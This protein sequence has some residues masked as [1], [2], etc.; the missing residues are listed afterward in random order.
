MKRGRIL[1]RTEK[2]PRE[3]TE[4]RVGKIAYDISRRFHRLGDENLAKHGVTLAQL[5]VLSYVS[6]NSKAGPVYQKDL[7]EAFEIRRSSVSGILHTME[8]S[9]ILLREGSPHDAR[10]KIISLTDKGKKLDE[11][12]IS[13]IYNLENDL[14]AG[15]NDGEK[16]LLGSF[17]CRILENLDEIERRNL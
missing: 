1:K 2:S 3:G 8:N 12:L 14:V 4:P 9:G 10:V 17:L 7:E 5:K 11:E 13:F 16:E 15:F 6:R